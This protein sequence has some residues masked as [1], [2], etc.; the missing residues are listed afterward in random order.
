MAWVISGRF[1]RPLQYTAINN[2]ST[3]TAAVASSVNDNA[4]S[5]SR[6]HDSPRLD[7]ASAILLSQVAVTQ[8]MGCLHVLFV[9]KDR[10][11]FAGHK[12][13]HSLFSRHLLAV[14]YYLGSWSFL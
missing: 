4:S 6:L 1:L 12:L 7:G 3:P 11:L 8:N 13:T 10:R 5:A 9:L 2:V 14:L